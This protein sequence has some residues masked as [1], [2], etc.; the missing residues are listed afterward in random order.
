MQV[1]GILIACA[2]GVCANH[3]Y[4][5]L[6]LAPTVHGARKLKTKIGTAGEVAQTRKL[7]PTCFSQLQET[8]SG[9][10]RLAPLVACS[11]CETSVKYGID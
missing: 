11:Y 1:F 8:D 5:Q 10:T 6:D 7:S 2:Q 9:G 4:L 3:P